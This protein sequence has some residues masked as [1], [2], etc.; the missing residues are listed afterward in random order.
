MNTQTSSTR[1]QKS[2]KRN[3]G[4]SK[5]VLKEYNKLFKRKEALN[6][7]HR[8]DSDEDDVGADIESSS[9]GQAQNS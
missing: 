1:A 8:W 3:L 9:N 6:L 5:S 2:G 4:T 7:M